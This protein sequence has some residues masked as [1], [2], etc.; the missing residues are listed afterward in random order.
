M[1]TLLLSLDWILG[2]VRR[3]LNKLHTLVQ[4]KKWK[5]HT[6]SITGP[7]PSGYEGCNPGNYL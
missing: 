1:L 2:P 3:S 4:E 6:S 5:R 7:N